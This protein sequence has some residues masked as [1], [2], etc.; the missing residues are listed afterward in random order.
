MIVNNFLSLDI[1]LKIL[2]LFF[3]LVIVY[4]LI[5]GIVKNVKDNKKITREEDTKKR[6]SVK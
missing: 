4:S 1:E 6:T 5:T 3:V 2:I